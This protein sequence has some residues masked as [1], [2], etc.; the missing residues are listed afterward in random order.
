[1]LS[2]LFALCHR[3]LQPMRLAVVF[4]PLAL[5]ACCA[6]AVHALGGIQQSSVQMTAITQHDDYRTSLLS[7]AGLKAVIASTDTVDRPI[8]CVYKAAWPV[9]KSQLTR[10]IAERW[11][12]GFSVSLRAFSFEPSL[13]AEPTMLMVFDASSPEYLTLRQLRL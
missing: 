2:F 7:T 10:R 1:M 13:V 8:N 9:G 6:L 12:P 3:L 5:V 4:M 11:S